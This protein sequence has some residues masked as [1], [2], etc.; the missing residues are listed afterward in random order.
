MWRYLRGNK[1]CEGPRHIICVDTETSRV[2]DADQPLESREVLRLGIA[3]RSRFPLGSQG[4]SNIYPFQTRRQF[5][6]WLLRQPKPR[7]VTW[8][9]A[10]GLGFDLRALGWGGEIDHGRLLLE[11]PARLHQSGPKA[12]QLQASRG[13]LLVLDSPP[14]IIDCWTQSGGHLRFVDSRNYWNRPL[15][16]LGDWL[17]LE[18]LPMPDP[19]APEEEW[20]TYCLRDCEILERA[21]HRL[22]DWHREH[23][24][25]VFKAT[26]AG[27]SMQAYRH[28]FMREPIVLH[29]ELDVKKLERAA[30]YA[31]RLECFFQGE[32]ERADTLLQ[33]PMPRQFDR[34][35]PRPTGVV[36]KLDCNSLFP[37]VMK[38]HLYPR[39]LLQWNLSPK[40][41]PVSS[42]TNTA[43][44]IASCSLSGCSICLPQR[45]NGRT[46]FVTGSFQT[47]L[48]G[49]ELE[50]ALASSSTVSIDAWSEYEL[51][52][53]FSHYVDYFWQLR[54]MNKLAGR[55]VEADL[56]KLLLNALYGKF[57]QRSY[58]WEP[59]PDNSAPEPWSNWVERDRESRTVHY[60]RSIGEL[61]QKKQEQGDHEHS[62]TA[63]S[64]FVTSYARR[65]MD[66]YR[67]ICGHHDCYYQGIDSLF[68]SRTGLGRLQDAGCIDQAALGK[69]RI[70]GE[71]HHTIF[72]GL[73]YYC[74]NGQWVRTSIRRG[75]REIAIGSWQQDQFESLEASCG[76]PQ[77][78]GVSV[79]TVI[80]TIDP[81][82]S[83][84]ELTPNGW[85]I[86]AKGTPCESLPSD[87][88]SACDLSA[89]RTKPVSPA[90]GGRAATT[91]SP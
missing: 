60:F 4:P 12:G 74:F 19:W 38:D 86:P 3:R 66:H 67:E 7:T 6:D 41:L 27:Q 2:A 56:C 46:A 87:V 83:A 13:G 91:P 8:V 45:A 40:S 32:I 79:K 1:S 76:K 14:T 65:K 26:A 70:E 72:R 36:Y 5:W 61:V 24:L 62:F 23:D 20:L 10:H 11:R 34:S 21:V 51:A 39:R 63:I 88:A 89:S 28:R 50:A 43:G 73:G 25:G 82:K 17:G 64:A 71:S 31:G 48:P 30:Y 85:V 55:S 18:K 42:L 35:A 22:L 29:D 33:D 75:A 58:E 57:G 53:L 37:S 16:D 59:E 47:T 15:A 90:G 44:L 69:L 80:R 77:Q 9:W 49:P 81:E 54:F 68:V 84:G 52:D 78:E